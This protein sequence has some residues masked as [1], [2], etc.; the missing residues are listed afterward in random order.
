MSIKNNHGKG[1]KKV[2]LILEIKIRIFII[3]NPKDMD[4]IIGR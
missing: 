3:I 2:I 4:K 1:E